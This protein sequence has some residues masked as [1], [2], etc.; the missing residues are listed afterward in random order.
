MVSD[1]FEENGLSWEKLVGVCTDGAPAMLGSCSGFVTLV[2]EK[3]PAVT[4]TLS[5]MHRQVL[6]A[7]T[8]PDDLRDSLNLAIKIVNFVKNRTLN[9]RLFAALCVDLGADHKILL[10]HTEVRWLSKGNMLSRLFELKDEVEIFPKQQK[11]EELYCEFMDQTFQLSLAYLVDI[12]ESLNNL[13]LKLQGNNAANIIAQHNAIKAFTEKI[14]LWKNQNQALMPNFSFFPTFSSLAENEGFQE[15]CKENAKNKIVFHL[16]CLADE[17]IRYFPDNFSGNPVH[18]LAH[19]PFN[20]DVDSLPEVLQ[21]QALKMKYDSSA[22]D[23]FENLSLE[24]FWLKYFP[25]YPKVGEE[26]LSIILLF[27][28][29]YLCEKSFSSLVIIKTKQRNRLDVENDVCCALSSFKPRISQLVKK[30]QHHLHMKFILFMLFLILNYVFIKFWCQE[31][32]FVLIFNF[33]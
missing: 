16:D 18:K 32:L 27:L 29:T 17:F 26:A 15:F 20:V 22:K 5:V 23:I 8:L 9:T 13:N 11:K 7:K 21:E 31:K 33:K 19:S 1:F 3:N 12:F 4:T 28:S 6:A 24:K 30:T 2:K 25:I 10:F 14:K